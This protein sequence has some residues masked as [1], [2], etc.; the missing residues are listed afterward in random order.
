MK[1]EKLTQHL[2]NFLTA[3]ATTEE[4]GKVHELLLILEQKEG[5]V[6]PHTTTRRRPSGSGRKGP[7]Y[8]AV[9]SFGDGGSVRDIGNKAR[10]LG[11]RLPP[12]PNERDRSVLS[13]LL[14]SPNVYM[15]NEDD[16]WRLLRRPTLKV[17]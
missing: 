2:R 6:S 13:K 10:E 17:V 12:D 3:E 9:E 16:T 5:L 8:R 15:K 1:Y 14:K 7:L 4:I 11:M